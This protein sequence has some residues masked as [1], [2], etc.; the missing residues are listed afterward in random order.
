MGIVAR[1]GKRE[2]FFQNT[3]LNLCMCDIN[4]HRINYIF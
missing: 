2:I 3:M 4:V 1:K